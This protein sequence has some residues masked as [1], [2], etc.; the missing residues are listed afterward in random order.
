[1]RRSFKPLPT[2]DS[3]N[4]RNLYADIAWF[5]VLSGISGAFLSVF[6]LRV[7][8]S[9]FHVGLLS[10]L[11]ALVLTGPNAPCGA[12]EFLSECRKTGVAL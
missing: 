10:A 1:M 6:I 7:G 2:L 5:G 8:G 4:A 3:Q 11:P 12:M 9:D